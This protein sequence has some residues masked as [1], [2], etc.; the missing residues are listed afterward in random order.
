MALL[1]RLPHHHAPFHPLTSWAHI[2]LNLPPNFPQDAVSSIIALST[3]AGSNQ[4]P[5]GPTSPSPPN[6]P[7]DAVSSII[8]MDFSTYASLFATTAILAPLLEETVF[9]GFLLTRLAWVLVLGILGVRGCVVRTAKLPVL[10][11]WP[12][13]DMPQHRLL[14][15]PPHHRPCN[16]PLQPDQVDACAG[17][18][19]ALLRGLWHGAPHAARLPAGK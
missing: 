12:P 15:C 9:R 5:L 19:G 4:I 11:V 18:S 10:P 6:F 16:A 2:P 13:G 1:C 14:T 7:Q 8:T 3:S 17:G